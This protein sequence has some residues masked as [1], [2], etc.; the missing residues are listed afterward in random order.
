MVDDKLA[1]A[2]SHELAE[3]IAAKQVSSAEM[4]GLYLERIDRL[5]SQLNS[6]LAL[7]RDEA[8]ET[9]RAA[10]AA[11]ANGDRLGPLHGVPISVKD[12][13]MTK[14]VVTTTGCLA[15]KAQRTWYSPS[16]TA[17]ARPPTD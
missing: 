14:G 3:L 15:Y 5:D 7:M 12:M 1:F 10:D 4:T 9:A 11:V 13:Q 2:P 6:Y 17:K 8:M 16:P